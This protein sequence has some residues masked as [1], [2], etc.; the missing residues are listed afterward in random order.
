MAN[1][2]ICFPVSFDVPSGVRMLPTRRGRCGRFAPAAVAT[3]GGDGVAQSGGG[4]SDHSERGGLSCIHWRVLG[5]T[6]EGAPSEILGALAALARDTRS[7][8]AFSWR[9]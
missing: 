9:L 2:I 5:V 6:S 1:T 7:P 4:R 3:V 8:V